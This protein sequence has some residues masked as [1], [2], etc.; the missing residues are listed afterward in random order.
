MEKVIRF[1]A[2]FK[3][4]L[5]INQSRARR[6]VFKLSL[7]SSE[8]LFSFQ[9]KFF[10]ICQIA[11]WLH[12]LPEQYFRRSKKYGVKLSIHLNIYIFKLF[13]LILLF[14]FTNEQ[15][16]A[17]QMLFLLALLIKRDTHFASL[18]LRSFW[19]K[20][21]PNL[22]LILKETIPWSHHLYAAIHK[23]R[24]YEEVAPETTWYL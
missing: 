5:K 16:I 10:Y 14:I 1:L 4:Y 24:P 23:T 19:C 17:Y 20:T 8:L 15:A 21:Q 18:D 7:P 22:L 6:W 2:A 11:Y 3:H 13:I 12:V 9:V